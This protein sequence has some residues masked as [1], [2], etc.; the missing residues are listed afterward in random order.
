MNKLFLLPIFLFFIGACSPSVDSSGGLSKKRPPSG[1]D[2]L[3]LD[4]D[5]GRLNGIG[6]MATPE[7][8][9]HQLPCAT[10][11]TEEGAEYHCGG[12]VFYSNLSVYFYTHAN[13]YEIRS[14]YPGDADIDLL[15]KTR[16]EV[17]A[18]IGKPSRTELLDTYYYDTNFGCISL[19]LYNSRTDK[20]GVHA[21]KCA[22]VK[23]CK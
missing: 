4:L 20:I 21:V 17:V 3:Y 8:V 22:E 7:E 13:F 23:R 9:K 1:C 18:I 11:E 19:H 2:E 5:R 12:G 15:N 10:A 16:E 14:G 6:P